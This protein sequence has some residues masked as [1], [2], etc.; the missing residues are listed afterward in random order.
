MIEPF[1]EFTL[2]YALV[3]SVD[4]TD[5]QKV[6]IYEKQP[7]CPITALI[8]RGAAHFEGWLADDLD[9]KGVWLGPTP[10]DSRMRGKQTLA[11]A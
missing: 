1:N 6:W 5:P 2:Y 11:A 10:D 9:A 8:F 4:L 3:P 7:G